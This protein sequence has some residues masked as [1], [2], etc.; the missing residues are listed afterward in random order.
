[1]HGP[2]FHKALLF[3]ELEAGSG[4]LF[5]LQPDIE[6]I[7][8]FQ[9]TITAIPT[10][11]DQWTELWATLPHFVHANHGRL[12]SSEQVENTCCKRKSHGK[13]KATMRQSS[14]SCRPL[15]WLFAKQI[16]NHLPTCLHV[17]IAQHNFHHINNEHCMNLGYT[18]FW[19][20]NAIWCSRQ[21]AEA[22]SKIFT[23][24]SEWPSI[25]AIGS[26]S[27]G[28]DCMVP[29]PQMHQ[30]ILVAGSSSR[31]TATTGNSRAFW[32][33]TAQATSP[34]PPTYS[35]IAALRA[36]GEPD[37]AWWEPS[38]HP[39]LLKQCCA[40]LNNVYIYESPQEA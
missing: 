5:E 31:C 26:I 4:W 15:V 2:V 14:M 36:E 28:V 25:Y 22:V 30:C 23:L 11:R 13:L 32:T 21:S 3:R 1:M 9:P 16:L 33:A 12:G 38:E 10:A 29:K 20:K 6:W 17:D 19:P 40:A 34:W 8:Q 37:Y 27:V 35:A 18:K 7:S 39:E 24:R